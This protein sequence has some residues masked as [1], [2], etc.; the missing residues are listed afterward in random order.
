MKTLWAYPAD[1]YQEVPRLG[2]RIVKTEYPNK[3]KGM[4]DDCMSL[5]WVEKGKKREK[6]MEF[7]G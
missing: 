3:E 6:N 7:M 1:Q 2:V 4:F 5:R